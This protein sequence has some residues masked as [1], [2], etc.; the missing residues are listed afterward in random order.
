MNLDSVIN[1][2][3]RANV[4]IPDHLWETFSKYPEFAVQV[5]YFARDSFDYGAYNGIYCVFADFDTRGAA[6]R[7][8]EEWE[9]YCDEL[10]EKYDALPD[11]EK[12][13]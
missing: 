5:E 3:F 1:T 8:V 4:D 12:S 6:E 11:K 13:K 9:E 7:F 2:T 10:Q